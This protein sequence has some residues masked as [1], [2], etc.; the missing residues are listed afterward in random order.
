M[1]KEKASKPNGFEPVHKSEF[2]KFICDLEQLL[3]KLSHRQ[4]KEIKRVVHKQFLRKFAKNQPPKYGT[5]NKGFTDKALQAF[6]A[7]VDTPKL[8]LLFSYQA[9]LGLRIG[10]VVK[11]NIKNIDFQ[12]RELTIKTEK[13]KVLNSVLIPIPLFRLTVEHIRLN[14]AAI[15]QSQGYLFF[16]DGCKHS[17]RSEPWLDSDYVRIRFRRYVQMAGL[18]QTYDASA[19]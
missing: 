11:L 15:E 17:G 6:F 9:Q 10:E 18:D 12:T 1:E 8:L 3:P 14:N 19:E 5:L 16:K 13:S 4:I 7:A 2:E